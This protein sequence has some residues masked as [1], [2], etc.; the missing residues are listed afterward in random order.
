MIVD[1]LPC[2]VEVRQRVEEPIPALSVIVRGPGVAHGGDVEA[3]TRQVLDRML[4][5][6]VDL[7]GFYELA[8]HDERLRGLAKQFRGMRPTRFPTVFE[9]IV[10]AVACQQL[11]LT[12][13]VHLLN[14][15]AERYGSDLGGVYESHSFPAPTQLSQAEVAE[16]RALGFST[17]KARV[18]VDI[19]RREVSGE[20]DLESLVDLDDETARR[21]LLGLAGIG[22]WSAEYVLLRGLGRLA[23]L[24]GDDV[25]A[26]NNLQRRFDLGHIADYETV[27][28]LA[29]EWW[30][31]GGLVYFHLLLDSLA[32][33][34]L[35]REGE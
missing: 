15:L 3:R 23:V 28:A 12:V 31:Y 22:R 29:R 1:E 4:G 6:S 9:A 10:N 5:L 7:T 24:P 21:I 17:A 34:I 19:A 16:L 2:E 35:T 8:E 27:A 32:E 14:R 11:S 18:L 20:L 13:G 26:R 33:R 25:G 30:P